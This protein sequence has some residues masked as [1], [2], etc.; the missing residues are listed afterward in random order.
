MAQ[1]FK[2][3]VIGH[4]SV[5]YS[6]SREIA[7]S[8]TPTITAYTVTAT[9]NAAMYAAGSRSYVVIP[10]APGATNIGVNYYC[11]QTLDQLL[12]RMNEDVTADLSVVGTLQVTGVATFDTAIVRKNTNT[13]VASGGSITAAQLAG[14]MISFTG[15][16][17]ALALPT[18]TDLA[19]EIGASAGTIFEFVLHNIAGTGTCTLTVGA[20]TTAVSAVTG[21]TTLTLANSATAGV[22]GFRYTFISATVAII[23]R[24]Y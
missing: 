9:S 18:A 15:A 16:V 7:F 13:S 19:T 24:L 5:V 14:G 17:G 21:G 3:D 2:A 22:A 1:V 11:T 20:N 8:S 23:S 4:N 10:A 12:A 6:A